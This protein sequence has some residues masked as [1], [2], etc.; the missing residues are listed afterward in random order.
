MST[1]DEDL[2]LNGDKRPKRSPGSKSLPRKR[3]AYNGQKRSDEFTIY[4]KPDLP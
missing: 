2:P 3:V 1:G 4:L